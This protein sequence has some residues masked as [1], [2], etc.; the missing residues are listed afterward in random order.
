VS[1][2]RHTGTIVSIGYEGRDLEGFMSA[3]RI[4][5]VDVV[6]D[7]R[8]TPISRKKGF[9]KT[10]L[11]GAL[12]DAGVDYLHLP[13]LGNPKENRDAFG[14]GRVEQG[15]ARFNERLDNGSGAAFDQVIELARARRVALLCFERDEKACHR[16]CITD[17]AQKAHPML[18]IVRA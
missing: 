16:W 7:V 14:D 4:N 18:H 10:A 15:R 13:E 3:L 6:V 2:E 17:R 8:L 11:S 1:G 5:R 9:S 12:V